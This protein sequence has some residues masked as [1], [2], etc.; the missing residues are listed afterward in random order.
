MENIPF[1]KKVIYCAY[2][3]VNGEKQYPKTAKFFRFLV[4]DDQAEEN[5]SAA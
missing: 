1:G 5:E 2:R 3:V 4:D